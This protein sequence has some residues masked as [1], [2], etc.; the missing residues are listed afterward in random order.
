MKKRRG[1]KRFLK[2]SQINKKSLYQIKM[3]FL[4]VR[5]C[6]IAAE[7]RESDG[8]ILENLEE[9]EKALNQ[10]TSTRNDSSMRCKHQVKLMMIPFHHMQSWKLASLCRSARISFQHPL[11]IN[12][13]ESL[14]LLSLTSVSHLIK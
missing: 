11:T 2:I 12:L 9:K 13:M 3:G 7:Q 4:R 6:Q 14:M 10:T 5:K 8:F 1:F